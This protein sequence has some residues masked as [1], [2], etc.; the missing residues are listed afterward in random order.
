MSKLKRLSVFEANLRLG[1]DLN[2]IKRKQKLVPYFRGEAC[3]TK[4]NFA[5]HLE[6]FQRWY[7]KCIVTILPRMPIAFYKILNKIPDLRNLTIR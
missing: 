4:I 5:G 2:D 7:L 6:Q 3:S 1:L